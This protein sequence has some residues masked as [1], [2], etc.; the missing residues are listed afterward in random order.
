MTRNLDRRIELMPPIHDTNLHAR[1]LHI[2][3]LQ[4]A[5]NQLRWQLNTDGTYA[6]IEPEKN[7]QAINSQELLEKY[8]SKIHDKVKKKTSNYVKKL[9]DKLLRES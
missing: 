6:L 9:A 1:I 5:D 8:V 2:L 3:H 7:G 4:L